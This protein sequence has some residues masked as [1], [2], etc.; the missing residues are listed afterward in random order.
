VDPP[1]LLIP[2]YIVYVVYIEAEQK[3]T[4]AEMNCLKT[5]EIRKTKTT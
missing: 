2:I 5:A 3:K 4:F 1:V